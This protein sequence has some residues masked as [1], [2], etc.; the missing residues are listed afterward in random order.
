MVYCSHLC[1]KTDLNHLHGGQN[2]PIFFGQIKQK[3][4]TVQG[5]KNCLMELPHFLIHIEK[6]VLHSGQGYRDYEVTV[7]TEQLRRISRNL[8]HSMRQNT[9]Q[10]IS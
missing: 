3:M 4:A 7:L 5:Y 8:S 1:V 10:K 9:F 6:L 2:C